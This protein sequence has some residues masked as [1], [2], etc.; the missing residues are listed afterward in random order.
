MVH[1]NNGLHLEYFISVFLFVKGLTDTTVTVTVIKTFVEDV[2]KLK[3][4]YP[5]FLTRCVMK[6]IQ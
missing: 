4:E 3:E 2:V 1:F 6:K 5:G